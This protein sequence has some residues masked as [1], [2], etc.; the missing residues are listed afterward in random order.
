VAA[1]Q[2]FSVRVGTR[3]HV[4]DVGADGRVIVDGVAFTVVSGADGRVAVRSDGGSDVALV[5]VGPGVA[6]TQAAM[7]GI[8]HA[9]EVLT[10][11]Q[12]ML[13]ATGGGS[14]G[15][16]DA[17]TVASP[18]PGRVVRVLVSEGESV[19]ADAPVVIVEAM[20][21]ENEVRVAKAA[22]VVRIAVSAGD[23]VDAGQLLV[24][25]EPVGDAG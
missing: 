6:P 4:V 15:G 11:Q 20:K 19:A 25:L 2:R 22:K 3:E 8:V 1:G 5:T 12:A 9:V 13:A 14:R 24:E 17:R 23:T 7:G 16:G 18:M 10:S 21:M